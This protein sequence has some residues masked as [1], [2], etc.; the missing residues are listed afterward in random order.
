MVHF[1]SVG[2]R[3]QAI[4]PSL[5]PLFGKNAWSF[6]NS[7]CRRGQGIL[8]DILALLLMPLLLANGTAKAAP[9]DGQVSES[10]KRPQKR[11]GAE[12]ASS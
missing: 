5:K 11:P 12:C 10:I 3:G 8:D 4:E 1:E 6:H 7:L 2:F 9:A